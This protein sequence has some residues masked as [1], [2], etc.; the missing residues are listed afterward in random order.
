MGAKI[1]ACPG[2][3]MIDLPRA[4]T[5]LGT[6]MINNLLS[7]ETYGLLKVTQNKFQNSLTKR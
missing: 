2:S 6:A 1:F 4:P 3:Q 5:I 7:V